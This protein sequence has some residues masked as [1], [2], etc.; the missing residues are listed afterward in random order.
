MTSSMPPFVKH[1]FFSLSTQVFH[2]VYKSMLSRQSMF[3]R[4]IKLHVI[5]M[6]KFI[7]VMWAGQHSRY[8]NC[9]RAERSG[10]RIPVGGKI[11]P[12]CPDQPW[13]PPSLLYNGY[14][15]FPGRKERPG[16]D[17]DPSPPSSAVVMKGQS[18]TSTP[19]MGH[20]AGTRV[21]FTLLFYYRNVFNA[22]LC[23]T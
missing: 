21:H 12:T 23:T 18:Y 7:T 10:D 3:P 17:A 13:G 22:D 19:P 5:F 1:C 2:R 4:D 6:I 16:C 11:F 8:S 15:V 20:T 14:Q 9:L